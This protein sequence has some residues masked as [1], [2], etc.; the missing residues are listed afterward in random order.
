MP[1]SEDCWENR[2]RCSAQSGC[3]INNITALSMPSFVRSIMLFTTGKVL[4]H[5]NDSFI[6]PNLSFHQVPVDYAP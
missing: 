1:T 6:R 5:A 3:S 2:R 4:C